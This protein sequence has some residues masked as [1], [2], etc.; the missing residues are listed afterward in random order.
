[1]KRKKLTKLSFE[2]LEREMPCLSEDDVSNVVG[3]A[4]GDWL[5]MLWWNVLNFFSPRDCAFNSFMYVYN[6]NAYND[7][8]PSGYQISYNE[9]VLNY[10]EQYGYPSSDGVNIGTFMSYVNNAYDVI[11]YQFQ[12]SIS[13]FSSTNII[14]IPSEG[15]S[16]HFVV[17]IEIIYD[18]NRNPTVIKYYDP[19]TNKYGTISVS[20]YKGLLDIMPDFDFIDSPID[21]P[22]NNYDYL[23]NNNYNYYS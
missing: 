3:G 23:Y 4:S 18:A 14:A 17:P 22:Y 15:Q 9:I 21:Y 7:I 10:I 20:E 19:S 12:G 2:A 6:N 1:M 16:L 8:N 13:N 5:R 11:M